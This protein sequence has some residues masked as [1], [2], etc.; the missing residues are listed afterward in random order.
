MDEEAKI[1]QT[2][3]FI[4]KYSCTSPQIAM[5]TGTGFSS[6][7]DEIIEDSLKIPYENIPNFPLSTV[8][9]H[10]GVLALGKVKGKSIVAMEGRVHLYEGYSPKDIAFPIRVMAGLGAK[11]LLITSAAGGIDPFL[12]T[13][14]LVL[15]NDHM[16]FTGTNPLIG[17][18][19]D[20]IGVR[21]PDMSSV[22]PIH[23]R[24]VAIQIA[25]EKNIS[26]K[27]GIYAGV[28]GPCLE[29]PAETR[30]LRMAGGHVVGMSTIQETIA[31]VHCGMLVLAIAVVT[32]INL[33][34]R[35][36]SSTIDDI[37][38]VATDAS[39]VLSVLWKSIIAELS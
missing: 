9:S 13:G 4:N 24:E 36:T 20:S 10:K 34:D 33:P 2:I 22:Y 30:F 37:I 39:S 1:Q 12:N 16:N 6:I 15:I 18:N 21:F 23:L 11:Y 5:I 17:K 8:K 27:E 25:I 32:N 28:I 29:T 7:I 3:E 38:S 31:A 26:L 14:D 35:M 19:I